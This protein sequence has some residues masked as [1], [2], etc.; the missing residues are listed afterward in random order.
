MFTH[1]IQADTRQSCRQSPGSYR[2]HCGPPITRAGASGCWWT[3]L[4]IRYARSLTHSPGPPLT[5]SLTHLRTHSPHSR[6]ECTPLP[7]HAEDALRSPPV[8]LQRPPSMAVMPQHPLPPAM[9]L[10]QFD[11]VSHAIS[12]CLAGPFWISFFVSWTSHHTVMDIGWELRVSAARP[13]RGS[14]QRRP[15]SRGTRRSASGTG[16]AP[17]WT[18]AHVS[19][20]LRS[21]HAGQC[22]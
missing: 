11:T 3:T 12:G 22:R 6:V 13:R 14:P 18:L 7:L 17:T 2:S 19:V 8:P 10:R 9:R 16:P 4:E 21:W 5:H 15:P 1:T 20:Q